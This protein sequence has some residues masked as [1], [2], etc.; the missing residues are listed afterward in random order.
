MWRWAREGGSERCISREPWRLPDLANST[1]ACF[2]IYNSSVLA[3]NAGVLPILPSFY[4]LLCHL[5]VCPQA[6][7]FLNLFS[8]SPQL[9]LPNVIYTYQGL[10]FGR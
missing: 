3:V 2:L 4:P 6:D 7:S 9:S 1:L 8:A 5:W 10:T